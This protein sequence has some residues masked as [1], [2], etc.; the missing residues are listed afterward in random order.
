[1]VT[2]AYNSSIWELETVGPQGL[3]AN[4]ASQ[5]RELRVQ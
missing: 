5:I 3:Q 4:Q 2:H 1:M